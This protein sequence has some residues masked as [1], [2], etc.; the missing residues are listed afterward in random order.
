MKKKKTKKPLRWSDRLRAQ[1]ADR[2]RTIAKLRAEADRN[3]NAGKYRCPPSSWW[4]KFNRHQDAIQKL[5]AELK[6]PQ[7]ELPL[8][9]PKTKA[10]KGAAA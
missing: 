5:V 8:P 9:E 4:R 1:I 6:R 2:E 7:L 3:R 10:K